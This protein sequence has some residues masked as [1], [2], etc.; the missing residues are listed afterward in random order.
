L[1]YRTAL[2]VPMLRE[3]SPIGVFVMWRREVRPFTDQQI[4]LVR[5][6][7]DQAVIAIENVRLF[8]E[9][10]SRNLALTEALE[11]QAATSE[12]LKVISRSA[13]DLQPVLDTLIENAAR[14]CD[15]RRGVILRRKGDS[16]HGVAFYNASPELVDFIKQH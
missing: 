11:R 8:T 7:A 15:A 6:F 1:G 4:E 5:T 10:Q 16:Y 9:V 2:A 12:V 3:S 13:F 14:L